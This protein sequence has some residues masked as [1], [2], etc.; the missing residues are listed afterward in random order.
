MELKEHY[1]KNQILVINTNNKFINAKIDIT[2]F[3]FLLLCKG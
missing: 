2:P 1:G 3:Y